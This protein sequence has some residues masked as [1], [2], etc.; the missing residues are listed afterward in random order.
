MPKAAAR[1]SEPKGVQP[2]PKSSPRQTSLTES[3]GNKLSKADSSSNSS[4][5]MS[6]TTSNASS[7]SDA[8][9]SFL[10]VELE[11]DEEDEVPV[12]DKCSDVR[13]KITRFLSSNT[14]V[15]GEFKK[16]GTPKPYMKTQ[17]CKDIGHVNGNSLKRF[18]SSKGETG[19]AENGTYYGA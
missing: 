19:G 17:F 2:Y 1:K 13:A 7:S 3:S 6:N 18:M 12:Y 16:D 14:P 4:K 5:P 8:S 11:G 9:G 15:P 10:D